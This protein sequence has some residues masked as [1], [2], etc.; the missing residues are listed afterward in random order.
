MQLSLAFRF[1]LPW[2][3]KIGSARFQR[4]VVDWVPWHDFRD[5][6]DIMDYMT[7]QIFDARK[8]AHFEDIMSI[9]STCTTV[10]PADFLIF[11][12]PTFYQCKKMPGPKMKTA[13]PMQRS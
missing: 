6:V 11:H 2:A 3:G 4:A 9:L 12:P 10:F 7:Q 13:C 1:I 8:S 5:I